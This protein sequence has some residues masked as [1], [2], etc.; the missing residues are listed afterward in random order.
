MAVGLALASVWIPADAWQGILRPACGGRVGFGLS[1]TNGHPPLT[2][3]AG[4]AGGGK[5]HRP[6]ALK[7]AT[8]DSD[9]PPPTEQ[10]RVMPDG[11][12]RIL[13]SLPLP[14]LPPPWNSTLAALVE[15]AGT[16]SRWRARAAGGQVS[17]KDWSVEDAVPAPSQSSFAVPPR[18]RSSPGTRSRWQHTTSKNTKRIPV[19]SP[20]QL[21]DLLHKGVSVYQMDIRGI[22]L[23]GTQDATGRLV[24][25]TNTRP[26]L[27]QLQHPVIAALQERRRTGSKPGARKDGHK[28]ALAIEGGGLRG[29]VSAGMASALAHLGIDECFDM[30]LGSSAGSIIGAYLV[31]RSTPETTYQYFCNYLTTSREHLSGA[32]WL[33][34]SRLLDLFRPQV[35]QKSPTHGKRVRIKRPTHSKRAMLNSHTHSKRAIRKSPTDSLRVDQR[36]SSRRAPRPVMLLDYPM[37]DIM[38]RL[39]PLDWE[40]FRENDRVQPMKV[41]TFFGKGHDFFWDLFGGHTWVGL[42]ESFLE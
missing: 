7:A 5:W 38:Q 30:V 29:C 9:A 1:P 39:C 24:S 4:S 20:Q 6:A 3:A 10:S 25:P 34:I 41:I 22:S 37:E 11:T 33:D 19:K 28:I 15:K 26:A 16:P 32:S 31:G 27:E 17:A 12:S 21:E 23:P 13:Q 18:I 14:V 8:E 35:P 2:T 42:S 40:T 36:A